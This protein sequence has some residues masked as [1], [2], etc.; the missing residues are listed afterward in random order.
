MPVTRN[1]FVIAREGGVVIKY[2]TGTPGTLPS[3]MNAL[4]CPKGTWNFNESAGEVDDNIDNWCSATQ[5]AIQ[6]FSP[7]ALTITISGTMEII[8]DDPVYQAMKLAIRN[9]TYSFFQL[10]MTDVD[11]ANTEVENLGGYLTQFNRQLQG[12]GPSDVATAF[13]ANEFL[14]AA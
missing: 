9:K 7:G 13:R 12:N 3:T 4:G 1:D 8:L 6:S 10:T 5:A 2:N 14:A 11:A